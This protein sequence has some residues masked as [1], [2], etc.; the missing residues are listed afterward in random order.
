[1]KHGCK[2][3]G[4]LGYS[5]EI[6]SSTPFISEIVLHN[7]KD[8]ELAISDIYIQFGRNVYLDML[9]KDTRIDKYQIIIPPFGTIVLKLGPAIRY[10]DHNGIVDVQELIAN[11]LSKGKIVLST[12]HG[13]VVAKTIKKMWSPMSD[14]FKNYGT[15]L[16]HVYRYYSKDS[17]YRDGKINE[18]VL[19]YSSYGDRTYYLVTLNLKNGH[20]IEYPI[21]GHTQPQVGKFEKLKFTDLILA[22]SDSLKE[23]LIK[24]K[25]NGTIDFEEIVSIVDCAK[26]IKDFNANL[27]KMPIYKPKEKNWFEYCII[28]RIQTILYN[29]RN[30]TRTRSK[31]KYQKIETHQNKAIM[32]RLSEQISKAM[33]LAYK[34]HEAQVDKGGQTYILHPLTVAM[35]LASQGYDEDTIIAGLLHDVIEDTP[36]SF[37]DLQTMG[38]HTPVI[39]ALRLLTHDKDTD[40]MDYVRK[41]KVNPIAKA[42]KMADLLH[43][44]DRSRLTVIT[45]KD[46]QRLAKYE[47][48]ITILTK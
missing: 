3:V 22:S 35:T 47:R 9:E 29:I 37:E 10:S 2:V 12:N 18:T 16:I 11:S 44:S 17:V 6:S 45:E 38:I 34:A 33:K 46:E 26:A 7:L 39:D 32:N 36:Y 28:N 30:R 13:K 21:Y 23:Y 41:V 15:D 5:S 25:E 1:M 27:S 8:K 42:V 20:Q 48:A 4:G 24:E 19:D 40:Y 43:N 31:K 14:Y